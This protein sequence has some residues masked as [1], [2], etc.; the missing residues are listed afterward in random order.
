VRL[1]AR[2][3]FL[4]VLGSLIPLALTAIVVD[5]ISSRHRR[6]LNAELY[7]K[8]ASG[9]ATYVETWTG[10]R[11]R[12]LDLAAGNFRLVG[13]EPELIEG[14]L[15]LVYLQDKAVNVAALVGAEAELLAPV[16]RVE[17]ASEAVAL[18]QGHQAVDDTRLEAF[19]ERLPDTTGGGTMVGQAWTPLGAGD[20]VVPIVLPMDQG[21]LAVELSLA[22]VGSFFRQQA[23]QGW[24][25]V[26]VDADGRLLAGTDGD[27]V[28]TSVMRAVGGQ[29]NGDARYVLDDGTV[30][31]ASFASVAAVG[32]RVVVAVP[33]SVAL[34]SDRAIQVRMA[35]MY[36]L[37][38]VIAGVL[39]ALGALQIVRPVEALKTHALRLAEGHLGER[40]RPSGTPELQE[41]GRALNFMSGRLQRN[42][43]EIAAAHAEIEAFNKQLQERV[44]ERTRE[45]R[46]AQSRLVQSSRLAAVAHMGAG[47]AHELNNPVAGILGAAQVVRMK[48]GDG[49]L[50]PLLTSLEAEAQRCRQILSTLNRLNEATDST[51][52]APMDLH[53]ILAGVLAAQADDFRLR[54]VA[55]VHENAPALVAD[56]DGALV[57]QALAQLARTF[58]ARLAPGSTLHVSGT[59][60]EG[61][62]MLAF[63]L[64]GATLEADDDW[65]ANGMGFW[66]A[67]HVL[68][69]HGGR[70]DEP[71]EQDQAVFVLHVPAAGS[72]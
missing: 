24:A 45:L 11:V 16:V 59:V 40:V 17:D 12:S 23:Q 52:R 10:D 68:A 55:L 27:L 53:E 32:W 4:I 39:G 57:G 15:R 64:E 34:R 58:R 49:P 62:A 72:G 67:R 65:L 71:D 1:R 14:F 56:V 36:V 70:L 48:H 30:V 5:R 42:R 38:L 54:G 3:I 19:I 51:E 47:L 43:E 21:R 60:S 63:R 44:E 50:S 9:L 2:I 29:V 25:V 26:L 37:A 18:F 13:L 6:V 28:D 33:E 46:E 66:I 8:R 69:L 35:Y 22:E 7:E 31:Q 20:A 61:V 41:L